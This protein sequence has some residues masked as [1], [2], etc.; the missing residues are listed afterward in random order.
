MRAET[1]CGR[2]SHQSNHRIVT[3]KGKLPFVFLPDNTTEKHWWDEYCKTSSVYSDNKHVTFSLAIQYHEKILS[4]PVKSNGRKNDRLE[5]D[6]D[7]YGLLSFIRKEVKTMLFSGL[8]GTIRKYN[9]F[10]QNLTHFCLVV[11]RCIGNRK[12]SPHGWATEP[13]GYAPRLWDFKM[14]DGRCFSAIMTTFCLFSQKFE[15]NKNRIVL[16]WAL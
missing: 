3:K 5:Q 6:W 10:T 12:T 7:R 9:F 13:V 4:V 15:S 14:S 1:P 11:K 2:T 16:N 8:L